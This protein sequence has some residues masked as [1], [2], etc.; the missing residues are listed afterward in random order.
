MTTSV[1]S[2]SDAEYPIYAWYGG[3]GVIYYY[4]EA[5]RLYLNQNSASMFDML[6]TLKIIEMSGF[7]TSKVTNMHA[8]FFNDASLE[9]LDLSDWDVSKVT[10]MSQMFSHCDKLKSVDLTD[11]YITQTF[12]GLDMFQDCPKL[13]TVYASESFDGTLANYNAFFEGPLSKLV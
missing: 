9:S 10:A 1:V 13:E 2:V 7:D 6:P 4:T 8:M 3:S 12:N 5:E 11:W